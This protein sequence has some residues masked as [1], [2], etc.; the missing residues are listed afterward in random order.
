M[1]AP[2]ISL[3]AP[4]G[5]NFPDIISKPPIELVFCIAYFVFCTICLF[6]GYFF[7][8]KSKGNNEQHKDRRLF[9]PELGDSKILQRMLPIKQ[10][11]ILQ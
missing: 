4:S 2:H 3:E 9:D 6:A 10:N 11:T 7:Y 5:C 8:M 1:M